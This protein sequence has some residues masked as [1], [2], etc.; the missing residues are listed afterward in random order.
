MKDSIRLIGGPKD[1]QWVPKSEVTGPS[2]SVQWHNPE[3]TI[4]L[5]PKQSQEGM[6]TL[7]YR[8]VSESE[9]VFEHKFRT[10]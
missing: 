7:V 9:A 1:G 5:A 10:P 3:A 4:G 6:W 8:V 2:F